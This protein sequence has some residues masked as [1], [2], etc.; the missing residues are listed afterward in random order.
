[1]EYKYLSKIDILYVEDQEDIKESFKKVLERRVNNFYTANDGEDGF[2]KYKILN[3]DIIITDITM[4]NVNGLDMISKIREENHSIPIIITTAFT[5]NSYTIKAIELGVN[6]FLLKPISKKRM[7]DVLNNN[8]KSILFEKEKFKNQKI[9]QKII[10]SQDSLILTTHNEKV[11]F[12]NKKLK[13]FFN[14]KDE[15]NINLKE[16]IFCKLN[17]TETTIKEIE[18]NCNN[19]ILSIKDRFFSFHIT[20]IDKD[21]YLFYL[22]DITT[23][24]KQSKE[25]ENRALHDELTSLY[26]KAAFNKILSEQMLFNNDLSLIMYDIDYFKEIN[27]TYGHLVG[28][29]VLKELSSLVSQNIR[30]N[31]ILARWGGEEFMI[32]IPNED[33]EEALNIA[34]KLNEIISKH[35]FNT[36]GKLT[37]SFGVTQ[38]KDLEDETELIKAVDKALYKAKWN[39][40]NRVEFY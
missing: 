22:N 19:Q 18:T 37:C 8:A 34:N 14:I 38:L 13:R 29:E 27:D 23:V 15:N 6:G 40:R 2:N 7:L 30:K 31:D 24:A 21:E 11:V 9:I 12:A 3:P 1:M 10:D 36:V 5:D 20:N 32:L 16:D 35:T 17:I 28:D 25:F 39:G 26:N 4:P 33:K